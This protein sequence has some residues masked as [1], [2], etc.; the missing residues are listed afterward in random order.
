[1]HYCFKAGTIT[2]M[3]NQESSAVYHRPPK[4]NNQALEHR[5]TELDELLNFSRKLSNILNL[6][7]LYALL[8]EIV[9]RKI[10]ADM[11]SIFIYRQKPKIFRLVYTYGVGE[12]NREFMFENIDALW[13][14]LMAN[15]PFSLHDDSGHPLYPDLNQRFHLDLLHADW[16][17]PMMMQNKVVGFLA[18]GGK[19]H[20]LPY[21]ETDVYFL[22]Q[23]AAQA[24]VCI[25]TC[26]LYLQRNKEKEELNRTLYNLSLLYNI[27][28]AMTYIS[29]LKSLLQYILNQ[30]IEITGAEKGSI[31]LYDIENNRLSV[32]VLAGLEDKAYQKKVNNNEIDC[33]SFKPGEG[34]AGRV[35]ETGR[36]MVVDKASEEELFVEPATSFVR[37]IACIPMK[38]YSDPIGVINVTNKLDDTGFS[39]EDVELLKAVSDQAAVAINKAQLWEMAVTD[40][41]TGLFVRRYFMVKL[42]EEFHRAERYEKNLSVVMADLDNFKDV[43]DT[44]GHSA[45][46]SVLKIIGK[47]LQRNIRDVDI[48][49]RFGGEEFVILL[50]EA[51]KEEARIVSERLRRTL[52]QLK[53]DDLPSLTISLGIAAYPE[54][55][56][57]I[58]KLIKRADAAMYVAKQTGRN[59]VIMYESGMDRIRSDTH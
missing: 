16:L 9:R 12:I 25:N 47:F 31:M 43:N 51:D 14:R 41:L 48:I 26:H 42:Q 21:S 33:R 27:G 30:A 24:A 38:V 1:M 5:V 13:Q 20:D 36:P 56:N 34:I 39:D 10:G 6:H 54:D 58:E 15:E 49:A 17:V 2:S 53:L 44:Y 11:F 59:R 45:G 32:R 18:V 28:R 40:S 46:D 37:S 22:R 4:E 7:E 8:S 57:S 19:G 35:F 55:G 23:I 3:I 29:D 50:P 52:A